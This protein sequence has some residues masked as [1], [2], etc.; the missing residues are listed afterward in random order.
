MSLIFRWEREKMNTTIMIQLC[1]I[2]CIISVILIGLCYV[3]LLP[4]LEE[5]Y[6]SNGKGI[7][8]K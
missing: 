4:L 7:S 8:G 6:E 5:A 1:L 2:A 3:I